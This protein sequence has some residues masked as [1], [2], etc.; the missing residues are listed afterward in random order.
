MWIGH[1]EWQFMCI[2]GDTIWVYQ[3]LMPVTCKDKIVVDV[4]A[5]LAAN[6]DLAR[7][8]ACE[9]VHLIMLHVLCMN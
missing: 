6:R 9:S 1:I 8:F 4:L 5:C 3:F 2:H 7:Q